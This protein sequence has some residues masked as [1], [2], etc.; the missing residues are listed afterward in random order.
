M[1][2]LS[3][4][5]QELP[6]D[7][8]RF[9]FDHIREDLLSHPLVAA[10]RQQYP[11]I[12]RQML[13]RSLGKLYQ[14]IK[15]KE[16]CEACTGLDTCGNLLKGHSSKLN[17]TGKYLDVSHSP[18]PKLINKMEQARRE[19]FI[20]SHH[21]PREVMAAK[22]SNMERDTRGRIL[23]SQSVMQ[24]CLTTSPGS[25]EVRQKGIYLYGD[26]GVGKSYMMAAATRKLAEREIASLMVYTPDFFREIKGSIQ[27]QTLQEKIN[28]LKKIP[29]LILDDIGAE[30]ISPWIRDEVLGAILHYRISENLPTLY[31]SNL[32]Y[33]GLEAHF[34]F[35]ERGGTELLKA[36]RIMERIRHYTD[37]Y[38][39]DG[40]NRRTQM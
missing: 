16:N 18:C 26:Y 34:S 38:F 21:I 29:V 2:S 13:E 22:F 27:D 37:E 30:T 36:K 1:K 35:S 23:A 33:D 5:I 32:N 4:L 40:V 24:F 7:K 6:F 25:K 39:V 3:H 28:V 10:F 12:D 31:T 20:Q 19:S 17:W 8:E 14:V 9:T 11:N 15:E